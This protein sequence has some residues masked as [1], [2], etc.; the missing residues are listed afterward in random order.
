[1]ISR[2]ILIIA[3]LFFAFGTAILSSFYSV[4]KKWQNLVLG[5]IGAMLLFYLTLFFTPSVAGTFSTPSLFEFSMDKF[6]VFIGAIFFVSLFT[7]L[8]P[9]RHKISLSPSFLYFIAGG[10]GIILS[11]N[12]STFF[13][14]WT[15]RGSVGDL[16]QIFLF[17]R[18]QDRGWLRNGR[19]SVTAQQTG[20]CTDQ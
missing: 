18:P 2:Q 8:Y 9:V 3:P 16:K 20:T 19:A 17:E 12:L 6:S 4:G 7:G 5:L 1:M 13:L 10:L 11:N 15:F 14:F